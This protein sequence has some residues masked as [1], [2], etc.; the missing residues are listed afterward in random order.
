MNWYT[1]LL[2]M[3]AFLIARWSIEEP[4]VEEAKVPVSSTVIEL[5]KK[6]QLVK[7]DTRIANP[8]PPA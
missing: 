8:L 4:Y 3:L 7:D 6:Y 2:V 1:V 5:P